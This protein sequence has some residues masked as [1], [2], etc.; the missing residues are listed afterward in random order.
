MANDEKGEMPMAY[1]K[2]SV[3]RCCWG[4]LVANKP[5]IYNTK[6]PFWSQNLIFV[7]SGSLE[8]FENFMKKHL[9]LCQTLKKKHQMLLDLN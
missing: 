3:Y 5:P 6:C 7:T 8:Q 1:V 9:N 4:I 2:K